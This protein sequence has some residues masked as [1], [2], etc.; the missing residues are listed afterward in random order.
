[1]LTYSDKRIACHTN[2]SNRF[3]DPVQNRSKPVALSY[4]GPRS[5]VALWS[6][7]VLRQNL[8]SR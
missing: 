5:G 1:M 6:G 7:R 2:E 8:S 4:C 3:R